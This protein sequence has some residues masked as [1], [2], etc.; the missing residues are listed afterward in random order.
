MR[1]A[2]AAIRIDLL[3]R[4]VQVSTEATIVAAGVTSCVNRYL[5]AIRIGVNQK[6]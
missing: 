2:S 5:V 1:M 6:M 3:V 4:Y